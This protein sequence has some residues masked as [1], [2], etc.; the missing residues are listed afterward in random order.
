MNRIS[1][2]SI[3]RDHGYRV[4]DRINTSNLCEYIKC[5]SKSGHY[6]FVKPDT[7]G[8]VSKSTSDYTYMITEDELV[9]YEMYVGLYKTAGTGVSGIGIESQDGITFVITTDSKYPTITNFI[10]DQSI[11]M[12]CPSNENLLAYPVVKLSE[13]VSHHD[14]ILRVI[15]LSSKN[16][17]RTQYALART[18]L[19]LLKDTMIK[20]TENMDTFIELK[21]LKLRELLKSIDELEDVA[22]GNEKCS[23]RDIIIPE[24]EEKDRQIT[25]NLEMRHNL[26]TGLIHMCNRM[27]TVCKLSS[28][29]DHIVEVIGHIHSKY[30]DLDKVL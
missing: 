29:N 22:A 9:P 5:L 17:M 23:G 18:R 16:I 20:V 2:E 11:R 25:N 30:D 14:H 24:K 13:I 26:F 8:V 6:V 12:I 3:L 1:L 28:V 10:N 15:K 21:E 4:I 27:C 7:R 19:K